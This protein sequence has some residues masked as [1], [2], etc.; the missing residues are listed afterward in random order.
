MRTLLLVAAVTFTVGAVRADDK[1]KSVE[2]AGM[3]S[4]LPAG[5]VEEKPS[6]SMRLSQCKIPKAA[7]D[8]ADAELAFFAFPGG[9][10]TLKQNLE[11]QL[12]K[13][14]PEGRTEKSEK[15]KVG[16]IDATLQ[17]VAGDFK[18]RA[19]PMATD[20]TM[21]KG[22][23]QLYVV[24]EGTDGKQYYGTLLGGSATVEAAKKPLVEFLKNFK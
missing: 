11:R 12:A 13:F 18:K 17:D 16:P 14:A 23:R 4:A 1:P 3:S 21:V 15:V 8:A 7:G 22:Q 24:F 6:N 9:S 10:G 2:L 19:F 5:W 20:Y